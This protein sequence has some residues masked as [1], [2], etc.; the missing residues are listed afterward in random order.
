LACLDARSAY[1]ADGYISVHV[2]RGAGGV[3]LGFR[4]GLGASTGAGGNFI[5]GYYLLIT[6]SGGVSGPLDSYE[7]TLLD[8]QGHTHIVGQ[9]SA[10]QS[11]L[12]KDFVL[13]VAF[14]GSQMKLY[15]NDV[16]LATVSD[17]TLA[18]GW[19][20]LCAYQGSSTFQAYQVYNLAG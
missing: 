4:E 7:L 13:G 5:D 8:A 3:A 9:P 15:V 12:A 6:S 11:N 20:G 10:L 14:H 1:Q 19:V 17:S 2:T 16:A 18:S